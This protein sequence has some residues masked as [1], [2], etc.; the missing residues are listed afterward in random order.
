MSLRL[1]FLVIT[2]CTLP[3]TQ[4]VGQ[5]I[6]DFTFDDTSDM[7]ASLKKNAAGTD[8]SGINP[9]ARS[10]GQG[11]YTLSDPNN[12]NAEQNLDLAI[13][14][15][16]FNSTES[17]YM[18]WDFRSQEEFAW[19]F[20]S[21]YA[22]PL[23]LFRFA[24][25]NYENQPDQQGFHLRYSTK[26]DTTTLISSGYVGEPLAHGERATIAFMY[27]KESG[28]A[29]IF[30]DGEEIWQTPDAKKTPGYALHWQSA[31]GSFF[32]GS[33]M[34]GNGSTTPSLYRFR[35][36]EEAC[37]N[38]SPPLVTGDTVCGQGPVTLRAEGGEEG[39][40]RWYQ[41]DGENF[42][43]LADEYGSTLT[44]ETLYESATYYVSVA[45]ADCESPRVPVQAVVQAVPAQPEVYFTPPCGPEELSLFIQNKQEGYTYRWYASEG[46]DPLHTADS[47][48]LMVSRD[49]TIYVSAFLD[50]CESAKLPV[51]ISLK[52]LPQIDAGMDR[53]ILKGE[54]IDLSATGSFASCYWTPHES[55]QFPDSPNPR[56][57]PESTQ[58]YVVTALS[59]DGCELSDTIR[60]FVLEKLPVPNA[61]SPNND[62]LNDSWEIPVLKDFP[63]CKME[64]YNKWGTLV[65]TS[66]G[67]GEAWDGTFQG[68]PV[69]AGTYYYKL[70]PGG[71]KP[72]TQGS[73]LILH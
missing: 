35:V 1:F 50:G 3:L 4:S 13:P 15:S 37:T 9:F 48:N 29:Y 22:Y 10:D 2:L 36:F 17:I 32:V 5:I 7:P 26:A 69:P 24:H 53:R 41:S 44:T 42:T 27:E 38:A 12:P 21:G 8:A 55:L 71:N 45:T 63:D 49:T 70:K 20:F 65:F 58:T 33:T 28:T 57:S 16:L 68:K 54:S 23:D 34:D 11:A 39:Q 40:Y 43:L 51:A 6:A 46:A 61:F 19:L 66:E 60:V 25:A 52:E 72:V 18:E 14:E 56:V 67:Y 64:V 62:G 30:R 47:L 73:V 31:N 59:A